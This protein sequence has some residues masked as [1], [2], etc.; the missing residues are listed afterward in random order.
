MPLRVTINDIALA[1]GLGKSTVARALSKHPH[2]RGAT[3]KLVEAKAAELGYTPDP[4]LRVLAQHRWNRPDLKGPAIAV[5]ALDHSVK[6]NAL[7]EYRADIR[8]SATRLGYTVNEF[9][10]KNYSSLSQL[11]RVIEAR[12][13]RGV[14]IPPVLDDM[15][16][17]TEWPWHK[18]AH[19]GCGIGEFRLPIHSV[20]QNYF[21]AVRLCWRQCVARGYKRIGACLYRQAGPDTNDSLRHAACLYEQ[22]HLPSDHVKIPLFDGVLRDDAAFLK[23]YRKHR[24]DVVI[25]LNERALWALKDQ[26]LAVPD[27]VGYCVIGQTRRSPTNA[28]GTLMPSARA[29]ECAIN[30][31]DQLLRTNE[32]GKPEFPDEILIETVWQEGG[33]MRP[34]LTPA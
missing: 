15:P 27:D 21:T 32:L 23:W 7:K 6:G 22:S 28:C 4:S 3:R 19:V 11:A 31:L 17:E 29:A 25:S 9:S 1:C 20:D 5:L 34:L 30:W 24:P 12:G 16:W 10:L 2:V 18:F 33:S 13:I 26:G 14:L 8:E